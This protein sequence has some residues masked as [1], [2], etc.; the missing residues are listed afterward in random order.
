MKF[1]IK[2]LIESVVK[3]EMAKLDEAKPFKVNPKYNVFALDKA[4]NKIINGWELDKKDPENM[5][6][7]IKKTSDFLKMDLKDLDVKPKDVSMAR[8]ETLKAKGID[9]F[10]WENWKKP[11]ADVK[12]GLFDK[13]EEGVSSDLVNSLIR[14]SK[15]KGQE[16]T[17]EKA[18]Q[19]IK[20]TLPKV[21]QTPPGGRQLSSDGLAAAIYTQYN[22]VKE[23]I[24]T[25]VTPDGKTL[26]S[27]QQ[28]QVKTA[29]PGS[30]IVTKKAG[31]IT[32]EA[33]LDEKKDKPAEDV[34]PV[35]DKP[36]EDAPA[37]AEGGSLSVE[38]N[39]HISSAID[40]AAKCIQDS[41]DK[42]YEKV[43]GKVLKNLTAAQVA[44]ED[45]QAHE[46]KLAEEAA[47]AAE[48]TNASY[49]K[50]LRKILKKYFKNPEHIEQVVKKYGKVIKQSTDKPVEKIAE[51]I[52]AHALREGLVQKGDMLK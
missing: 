46:T 32:E 18:T 52:T 36:I 26:T 3:E 1:D 16:F 44:L 43:L 14:L 35:E 49:T 45:V 30:T 51:M 11:D 39:K 48:K 2:S 47:V 41:G 42:K 34:P 27:A 5:A 10:N 21:K 19:V 38:L 7:Y 40:A 24:T 9:P 6:D 50:D 17:K 25:I 29:K 12:E 23:A 37:P 15:T 33:E 31:E 13:K 28:A 4:T 20:D 8:T 22:T